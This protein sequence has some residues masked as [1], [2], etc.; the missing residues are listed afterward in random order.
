[1]ESLNLL[2]KIIEYIKVRR[3]LSFTDMIGALWSF[4]AYKL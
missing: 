2:Y 1:M 3:Y 4:R